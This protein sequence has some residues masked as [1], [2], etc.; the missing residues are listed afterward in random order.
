MLMLGFSY[1][2]VPLYQLYCQATGLGGIAS[3][4]SSADLLSNESFLEGVKDRDQG[5]DF[6]QP[7]DK[8]KGGL[9][10]VDRKKVLTVHFNSETS[11]DMPWTFKPTI[12]KM[13]V[14]P[15]DT[16]LTFYMAENKT[17]E[18]VSGISTYNVTPQKAGVYFN[19]IQCFC[20]EEQRLKPNES[21]EMPILFFI[22]S[23][24]LKDPKMKDVS[25]ITLSY[26]FYKCS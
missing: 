16:A 2:S 21:I 1:A 14:Y 9:E 5:E 19:K 20:F 4:K 6:L 10:D 23:E 3:A 7:E 15:G 18:A 13:K 8:V 22:D 11:E 17:N 26:T 24:F 25:T 12:Q